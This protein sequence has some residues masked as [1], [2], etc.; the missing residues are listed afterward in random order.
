MNT[1]D[2]PARFAGGP[3]AAA[4][5]SASRTAN[6]TRRLSLMIGA[7]ALLASV[8]GC[9]GGSTTI[10]EGSTPSAPAATTSRDCVAKRNV[11]GHDV[12]LL[13]GQS[14]MAGYGAY[15]VPAFD[16]PDPRVRQWTRGGTIAEATEPLDHPQIPFNNGRIGPGLAFG[17]AYIADLPAS[18][19]VLLVPGAWGGTGF[20]SGS[21]N[22]GD[23]LYEQAVQ[24]TK[25]ALALNPAG[26]CLA[27]ILWSQGETDAL[28]QM[29]EASYRS[30]LRTMISSMRSALASGS[31]VPNDIPFVLGQFSPDWIAPAPTAAQQAILNVINET[32]GAV[33]TTAIA[34]TGG[35]TSNLTQG[36]EN[37]SIH[38]DAA[39]Q[40]TYGSRY[41]E[42]L[43]AAVANS[44]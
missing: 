37:G 3:S 9:G 31:V 5:A 21:W 2:R 40:R 33:S 23:S 44:R 1:E 17:K 11:A 24:R 20:S 29:P 12:V 18:R 27:G 22:P 10:P 8:A 4:A 25:A 6:R 15:L 38:L 30:A 28:N 13:I 16:N 41:R 43:K 7:S 34:S 42:A 26:N 39:S 35:L 19:S 14:N 32:P 36:L